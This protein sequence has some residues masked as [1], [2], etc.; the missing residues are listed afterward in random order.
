MN[1]QVEW[2]GRPIHS[3]AQFHHIVKQPD[4]PLLARLDEYDDSLLVAGCQ[5]SG[6]TAVTRLLK[7]ADG[8]SDFQ[9]GR[10]DEL[11]GA[12]LLSGY[13]APIAEGRH[14]FQTTYL[15]DRYP[16]Y[17]DHAGFRLIWILRE[18]RA[19]VYS[20]LYNWRRGALRR[21]Y[22][23][24]GRSWL[25]AEKPRRGGVGDLIG[26]SRLD[27][28]CASYVAKTAQTFVLRER[29]GDRMLVVD[30]DDLVLHKAALLGDICAFAGVPFDASLLD[31]LHGRS[32]RRGNRLSEAQTARVDHVCSRI[33]RDA[34]ALR[35]VGDVPGNPHAG[36]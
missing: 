21:L 16:E 4:R 5:R 31:R 11:D 36:G 33:Y 24:C 32:I 9:F 27:K 23:A 10:D 3:W 29:L 35:T 15:N 7:Q 13:V 18:P 22:D 25:D 20:M 30:Y 28:A 26:P 6:T 34:R 1:G 2:R 14:C 8:I 12:L 17:F 19:D